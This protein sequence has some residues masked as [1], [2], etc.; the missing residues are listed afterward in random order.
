MKAK[1]LDQK[2][3]IGADAGAEE[4]TLTPHQQSAYDLLE[5][6]AVGGEDRLLA[7]LIGYAGT[8]KTTLIARLVRALS[9][10]IKIAVAAPTNK[11]VA[12]LA[13]KIGVDSI[14]ASSIHSLLGLKLSEQE[15]GEAHCEQDGE[16]SLHE[17]QLVI[18]DEASMVGTDLFRYIMLHK[19]GCRVLFVGDPAQLPPV[20][21]AEASPVFRMVDHKV[22]LS[23]VVRQ[24]AGNPIIGLSMQIRRWIEDDRRPSSVDLAAA[25]A[26]TAGR[27]ASVVPGDAET[28]RNFATY[29]I[30]E[31]GHSCRVISFTNRAVVAHND[32]IHFKVHGPTPYPFCEG[33]I[34]IAQEAFK[35][36]LLGSPLS[37]DVLNSSEL[38]VVSVQPGRHEK[39]QEIEALRVALRDDA[40]RMIECFIPANQVQFDSVLADG[41]RR[42]R[43]AKTEAQAASDNR[44]DDAP[45]LLRKAREISSENW[46]RKR[47][48][49]PIRHAYAVTAHKSQGS[50]FDTVIVD[51]N[52]LAKMKSA[53]DF[54]RALYVAATRAAK[55]M[56]IVV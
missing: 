25:I 35:A 7:V 46:A 23:E 10:R 34:V 55:H 13:E 6:F 29:V 4:V 53:F 49:A 9:A 27:E 40:D 47:A 12:V 48:F 18:V 1:E 5:R 42:W 37:V 2:A 14:H 36:R 33:E 19:R 52:D 44:R 54:N 30:K 15:N 31:E 17:F 38:T 45:T 43:A 28:I 21:E 56:A 11:A 20:G 8:G 16:A 32:A 24:A 22:M 3:G 41:W 50:T 26:P 39:F 51:L